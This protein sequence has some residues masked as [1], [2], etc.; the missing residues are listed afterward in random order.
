MHRLALIALAA[1]AVGCSSTPVLQSAPA[2]RPPIVDGSES[3]WVGALQPVEGHTGV[4]LGVREDAD[5][6]YV[7]AVL[8]GER[9]VRSALADGLTL[10]LDPAGG[11]DRALGLRYPVGLG[12]RGRTGASPGGDGEPDAVRERFTEATRDLEVLRD[13]AETGARTP[14]AGS[15][16][17]QAA[18]TLDAGVLVVEYRVPRGTG[19][20]GP[21]LSG[22]VVG[23]GL[24]TPEGTRPEGAARGG[25]GGR[26]GR[27]GG[28]GRGG[29]GGG[30]P[31]GGRAERPEPLDVW[32]RVELAAAQGRR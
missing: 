4:A 10:W 20:N 23:L 31:E 14:A 30:R 12:A 24:V 28:A 16:G 6:L 2:A 22:D 21:G 15:T 9:Q 29:Q 19:A 32:V 13:G 11:N 5:A 17:L 25:Q 8:R 18:A 7:V 27:G 3:D 1:L 26:G